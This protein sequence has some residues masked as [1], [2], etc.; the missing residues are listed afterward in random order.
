M[1]YFN[2]MVWAI[3]AVASLLPVSVFVMALLD[4]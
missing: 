4:L 2:E 3:S 1:E